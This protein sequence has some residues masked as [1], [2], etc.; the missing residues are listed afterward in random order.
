VCQILCARGLFAVRFRMLIRF[1]FFALSDVLLPVLSG[2]PAE[3]GIPC[4]S[5]ADAACP[6]YRA[7]LLIPGAAALSRRITRRPFPSVM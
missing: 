1:L 3:P 4:C 7:A 6:G 5:G 2:D